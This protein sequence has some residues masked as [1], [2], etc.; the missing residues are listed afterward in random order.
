M[1]KTSSK[2]SSLDLIS[3]K[4]VVLSVFVNLGLSK[5]SALRNKRQD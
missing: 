2:D 3:L 4:K 5:G 1:T